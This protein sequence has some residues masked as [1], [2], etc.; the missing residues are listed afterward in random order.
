[1]R[2][3]ALRAPLAIGG[4]EGR[5]Q[6][7]NK[8]YFQKWYVVDA[9]LMIMKYISIWRGE[10]PLLKMEQ[11]HYLKTLGLNTAGTLVILEGFK[12]PTKVKQDLLSVYKTT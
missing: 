3:E 4:G 2:Q 7:I 8:K 6:A 12:I 1:M 9:L 5:S 10:W 11:S